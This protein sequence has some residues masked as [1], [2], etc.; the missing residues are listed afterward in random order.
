MI[1][2]QVLRILRRS[3]GAL[4]QVLAKYSRD[5]LLRKMPHGSV[6]AEIGVYID[7]NHLYEF[8]KG[9]LEVYWSKVKS[10]GYIAGDDYGV[11]GW[12]QNGV[13]KAVDEFRSK[14]LCET[15]LIR[16]RQFLLQRI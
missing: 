13:T 6:C 15:I 11:R 14:R 4:R 9:D 16:D 12:W 7:G 2:H 3:R 5:A 1:P 10:G 8:V